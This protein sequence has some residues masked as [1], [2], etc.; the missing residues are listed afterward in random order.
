MTYQVNNITWFVHPF[1][2]FGFTEDEIELACNKTDI[3]E[4]LKRRK[5]ITEQLDINDY[6]LFKKDVEKRQEF[7]SVLLEIRKNNDKK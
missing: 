7:L 4:Y 2:S 5:Q 1:Y 6:H 3:Y